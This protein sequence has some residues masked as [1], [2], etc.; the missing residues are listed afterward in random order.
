MRSCRLT[1]LLQVFLAGLLVEPR[2]LEQE[3]AGGRK[4]QNG[5]PQLHHLAREPEGLEQAEDK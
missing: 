2:V 3:A 4:M 1:Q 5:R